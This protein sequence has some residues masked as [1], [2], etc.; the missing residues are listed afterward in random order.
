MEASRKPIGKTMA[1]CHFWW[2]C[3]LPQDVLLLLLIL[4]DLQPPRPCSISN[5]SGSA[6]QL[7]SPSTKS[8]TSVKL[9]QSAFSI[10]P[11]AAIMSLMSIV[12]ILVQL[13]LLICD[14]PAARH[15]SLFYF[16]FLLHMVK[17]LRIFSTVWQAVE[18]PNGPVL[19]T[20]L[21]QQPA[22][23]RHLRWYLTTEVCFGFVYC[24]LE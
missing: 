8:L 15:H 23:K 4:H 3:T 17:C 20:A 11:K 14:I 7:G 10:C 18:V 19:Q 6:H 24:V 2:I 9:C 12:T 1:I 21:A 13:F 22:W 5:S 16:W